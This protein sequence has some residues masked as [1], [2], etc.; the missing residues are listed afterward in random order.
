MPGIVVVAT[1]VCPL[2]HSWL[3]SLHWN[4]ACSC[5]EEE[6]CQNACKENCGLH[7]QPC[8]P[9]SWQC[10][11][12]VQNGTQVGSGRVGMCMPGYVH[13]L[14]PVGSGRVGPHLP[15]C[16]HWFLPLC[17]CTHLTISWEMIMRPWTRGAARNPRKRG[18]AGRTLILCNKWCTC[19]V[20]F[21]SSSL[22]RQP[23]Q[24]KVNSAPALE[25]TLT[26]H[27]FLRLHTSM[28]YN[29]F[30]CFQPWADLKALPAQK[31]STKP[32]TFCDLSQKWI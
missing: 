24:M 23:C 19:P 17:V 9:E 13:L 7:W 27:V 31:Q 20:V 25:L 2:W 18:I 16:D 28:L 21:F 11:G 15:A 10:L 29:G 1:T 30:H 14:L 22:V 4:A 32:L 3:S 8:L 12:N 26:K 5:L 6:S